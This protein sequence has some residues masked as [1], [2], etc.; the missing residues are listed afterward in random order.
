MK[1]KPK[2]IVIVL[3]FFIVIGIFGTIFNIYLRTNNS[4]STGA[5]VN[6]KINIPNEKPNIPNI[7]LIESHLEKNSLSGLIVYGFIKNNLKENLSYLEVRVKFY[8]SN[9]NL[10]DT[11]TDSI[12]FINSNE[13]WKFMVNYPR[14]DFNEINNYSI[15][16]GQYW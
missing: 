11:E 13:S 6:N 4:T 9:R 16:I 15:E 10:L 12:N 2:K 14:L 7:E 1:E 5:A 8:D 3:C